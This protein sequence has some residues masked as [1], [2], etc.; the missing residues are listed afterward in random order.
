MDVMVFN[1][2]NPTVHN[3]AECFALKA[4]FMLSNTI[5]TAS[6]MAGYYM[7]IDNLYN[8][9]MSYESKLNIMLDY[10]GDKD[11]IIKKVRVAYKNAINTKNKPP[12]LVV[13]QKQMEQHIDVL[14][15]SY[16]KILQGASKKYGYDAFTELSNRRYVGYM[17]FQREQLE[18]NPEDDNSKC[19]LS[20]I[21]EFL[22][23]DDEHD[24]TENIELADDEIVIE[25]KICLG[26]T[27]EFLNYVRALKEKKDEQRLSKIQIHPFITLPNFIPF[28]G[29]ELEA[30]HN[31]L[32]PIREEWNKTTNEWVTLCKENEPNADDFFRKHVLPFKHKLQELI[33]S[34]PGILR[35][36]RE[37]AF[38]VFIGKVHIQILIEYYSQL[39]ILPELSL[40]RLNKLLI[41]INKQNN[42]VP[43]VATDLIMSEEFLQQKNTEEHTINSVKKSLDIE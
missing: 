24:N 42:Y 32:S 26:L 11:Q 27:I 35:P 5:F 30:M 25:N 19:N 29:L 7:N 15:K 34:Y 12:K 21:L 8:R 3:E 38:E 14:Y 13:L 4:G 20:E 23:V 16:V 43:V 41:S 6:D 1:L 40:E 39:G 17:S 28:S 31:M 37:P 10:E 22:V 18:G 36:N 2:E 9:K 33:N